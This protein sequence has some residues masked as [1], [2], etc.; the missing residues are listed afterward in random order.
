MK[1]ETALRLRDALNEAITE[2][3]AAR[4]VPATRTDELADTLGDA[5]TDDI[6]YDAGSFDDESSKAAAQRIEKTQKAMLEAAAVLRRLASLRIGVWIHGGNVVGVFSDRDVP[7]LS[8]RVVDLDSHGASPDNI[9][10]V[11]QGRVWVKAL[12]TDWGVEH[13]PTLN[14]QEDFRGPD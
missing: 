3:Q 1:L 14:W 12:V 11:R 9:T 2:L 6:W 7:D 10:E 13:V 5:V 8:V 4:V